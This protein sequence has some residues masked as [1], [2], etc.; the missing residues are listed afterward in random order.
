MLVA[1]R[2]AHWH[3]LVR[4]AP[5]LVG[6]SP[7]ALR[8]QPESI[9]LL[10]RDAV[11]LR[12]VLARLAHR[13]ER[14][15]LGH[16]WIGKTPAQGGV[17]NRPVAARKAILGLT[18]DERAAAHRFAAAGDLQFSPSPPDRATSR[19]Q[20]ASPRPAESGSPLPPARTGHSTHR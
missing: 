16:P 8:L 2:V 3:E 18:E 11:A 7:A 9:L 13:L 15:H 20:R 14:E 10:P 17:V 6:S 4:E 5:R 19:D 1:P 12:H